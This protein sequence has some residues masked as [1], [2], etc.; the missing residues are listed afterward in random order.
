MEFKSINFKKAY[1]N[2][3]KWAIIYPLVIV[4]ILIICAI[5]VFKFSEY[6][7]NLDFEIALLV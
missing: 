4:F 1:K 2:Y 6:K 3:K 5:V 7:N